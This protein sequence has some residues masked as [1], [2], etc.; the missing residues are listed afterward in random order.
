MEE[1]ELWNGLGGKLH[2]EQLQ[3]GY[4]YNCY[5]FGLQQDFLGTIR[6]RNKS[7]FGKVLLTLFGGSVFLWGI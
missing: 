4:Y 6:K 7:L 2:K 3:M 1:M 5:L